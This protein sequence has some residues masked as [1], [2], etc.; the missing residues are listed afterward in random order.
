MSATKTTES[1]KPL[2]RRAQI[3]AILQQLSPA[4]MHAFLLDSALYNDELRDNLLISFG[5]LLS[6][7][8]PE[9]AKYRR[10][11]QTMINRH[12][13]SQG[14]IHQDGAHKL[15]ASL[16]HLLETASKATTPTRETIDLCIA[17]ISTLPRLGE[18]MEDGEGYI[19]QIMR[20]ACSALWECFN[21]LPASDQQTLFE[22]ML[23][24]YAEPVYLDLDLDSF[25]LTLLKDWAK[26]NKDWQKACLRHQEL[27]L[28]SVGND[29]WRKNYLLEQ[30]NEL[31]KS[32]RQVK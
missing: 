21:C 7:D 29:K 32:W 28:K 19:Y 12:A 27:L 10:T 11:L 14:F 13:N 31:L 6:S 30:T 26:D 16:T 20:L 5:D 1:A 9:E 3:E 15:A 24:E 25:L 17:T 23:L 22:R 4:Q 8:Q 2:T 18:K